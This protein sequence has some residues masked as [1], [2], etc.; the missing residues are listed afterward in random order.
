MVRGGSTVAFRVTVP[1]CAVATVRYAFSDAPARHALVVLD[2]ERDCGRVHYA[3][4]AAATAAVASPPLAGGRAG[5]SSAQ[6]WPAG[7]RGRCRRRGGRARGCPHVVI[8][9][10]ESVHGLS[11]G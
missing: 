9:L 8:G 10:M 6:A 3:F 1:P 2:G 5:P 11:T 7:R 4:A